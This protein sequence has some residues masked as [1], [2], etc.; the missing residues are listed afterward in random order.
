MDLTC[1]LPVTNMIQLFSIYNC[2]RPNLVSTKKFRLLASLEHPK[3]FPVGS[4][5][6]LRSSALVQNQSVVLLIWTMKWNEWYSK[7]T[8]SY[9]WLNQF[10][11]Y[12]MKI[13]SYIHCANG[14][15]CTIAQVSILFV[16]YFTQ[17]NKNNFLSTF[18]SLLFLLSVNNLSIWQYRYL[19][20]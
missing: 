8:I 19:S 15:K 13:I 4:G 14:Y 20:T 10:M 18:P 7:Q 1:I 16:V 2:I 6:F 12:I 9:S 5:G 3:N 17:N 11:Q